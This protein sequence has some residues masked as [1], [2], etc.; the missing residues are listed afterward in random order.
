MRKKV[1]ILDNYDSFTHNLVQ[2][3]AE[4]E[5]CD[6]EVHFNNKINCHLVSKFDK[7]LFSPGPDLPSKV[8]L[9]YEIL[10]KFGKTKS[11]LGICL[12]HQAIGEFFGA[13]LTNLSQVFHGKKE[14]IVILDSTEILFQN[15]PSEIEVGLYH[16]WAISQESF[17]EN[18]KIT[19]KSNGGIVMAISHKT[20][21]IKGLQ[22]HPE[23]IMTDLGREIIFQ[24][25][26]N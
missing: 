19:A 5:L 15:L 22:F 13:K 23:S 20:L 26:K 21:N 7:I 25:L 14:K 8:P 1:L 12:G 2:I 10:E 4:S 3:L 24:W 16:S 18:L 9:M 17:P 11:I 6:F